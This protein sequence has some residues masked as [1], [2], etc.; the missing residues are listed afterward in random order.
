MISYDFDYYKP[1]SIKE[2]T[3]L[4][5]RLVSEGRKPTYFSGGTE[6]LT[7][8]RLNLVYTD[9][10][11]DI[12]EIPECKKW[13]FEKSELIAGAAL[14]LSVLE[15]EPRFPL[16]MQTASEVADY[17]SRNKITLGGNICGQIFYR[18]AVLPFLLSESDVLVAGRT[19][20]RR[21]PIRTMFQ[22]ELALE[23]GEFLVQIITEKTYV[24]APF[25]SVKK[26]QQWET[27]YPLITVA[28]LK[29]DG[30]LRFAFSGV[31]AFPFRSDEMERVLND[32]TMNYENR[33]L[34]SFHYLPKPILNDMEGSAEYRLFVLKNTLVDFLEHFES[35]GV[36]E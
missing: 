30:F 4:Y 32:T 13:G 16:L 33:V 14:P 1:T 8:G 23:S 26:R 2:A 6:I 28:S 21:V 12:K 9:A 31:C 18:E 36:H 5:H 35:G 19:G 10:V 25:L 20:V 15:D 3:E 24:D 22:Q 29:K 27:G 34:R 7:L 11:I 17:T